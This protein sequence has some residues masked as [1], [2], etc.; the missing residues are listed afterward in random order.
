VFGRILPVEELAGNESED[1]VAKELEALV[2][3]AG[4][5]TGDAQIGAVRQREPEELDA[6]ERQPVVLLEGG[7]D[8]RFLFAERRRPRRPPGG[9]AG[10]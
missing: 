1:R 7:E 6:G 4:P 2:A 3:V 9:P 5:L 8:P 10:E